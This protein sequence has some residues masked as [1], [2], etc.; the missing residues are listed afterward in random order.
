VLAVL[1]PSDVPE[2]LSRF[3]QLLHPAEKVSAREILRGVLKILLRQGELRL[4]EVFAVVVMA[5]VVVVAMVMVMAM[6]VVV[7]VVVVQQ[8][9]R[10]TETETETEG[11]AHR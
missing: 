9:V 7:V 11:N 1:R 4:A 2:M 3:A 5:M 10:E 6:V 8:L